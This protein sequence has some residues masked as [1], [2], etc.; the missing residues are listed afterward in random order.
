MP[1]PDDLSRS[2]AAQSHSQPPPD[3][4]PWKDWFLSLLV[5]MANSTGLS[6]PL[7]VTVDGFMVTGDLCSGMDFFNDFGESF[8]AGAKNEGDKAAMKQTFVG[9]AADVYNRSD[10]DDN[11]DY[12]GYLHLKDARFFSSPHSPMPGNRGVFWRC[13]IGSVSGFF[14]GKLEAN[15]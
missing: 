15:Q 12:I 3:E 9:L 5:S 4:G 2:Q 1:N 11:E 7:T 10:R 8:S 6:L 14:L 13:R